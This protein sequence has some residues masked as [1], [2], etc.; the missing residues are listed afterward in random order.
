MDPTSNAQGTDFQGIVT[1]ASDRPHRLSQP[2]AK[3]PDLLGSNW[4]L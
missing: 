4:S 2:C 3:R 1:R